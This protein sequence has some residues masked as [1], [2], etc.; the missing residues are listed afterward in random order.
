MLVVVAV[1]VVVVPVPKSWSRF[2]VMLVVDQPQIDPNLYRR[3]NRK[4]KS[5]KC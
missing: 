5:I 2:L 1:V 4:E 3:K